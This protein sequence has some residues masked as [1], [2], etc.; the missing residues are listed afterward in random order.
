MSARVHVV[1]ALELD[2]PEGWTMPAG[3]AA[4][5][6]S[7]RIIL[8]ERTGFA[9]L[10]QSLLQCPPSVAGARFTDL[11]EEAL[12]VLSGEG[13]LRSQTGAQRLEAETG[14]CCGPGT[15]YELACCGE[16]P[17]KL[18]CVRIP[19]PVPGARPGAIAVRR[20]AEQL[21]GQAT[22]DREFRIVA[23]PASGLASATLFV[24]WI[25]PSRAPDHFHTYDEVIY[26]LDGRGRMHAGQRS[27]SV[28]TGSCIQLPAGTVHCLEN[29][30]AQAMRVVAVFR[31]AGSPAAAYYPDGSPAHPSAP[32]LEHMHTNAGG[33]ST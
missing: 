12:F 5:A 10:E 25:P 8:G 27:W 13:E 20:L 6:L 11:A 21:V 15:R 29:T 3:D 30:G 1:S 26:V 24:G 9:A 18:I 28:Q 2:D 16:E 22:G 19:A 7:E 33:D 4:G 32:P 23:D 31:P 14:I 17:L